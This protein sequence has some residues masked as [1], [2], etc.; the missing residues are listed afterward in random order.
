MSLKMASATPSQEVPAVSGVDGINEEGLLAHEATTVDFLPEPLPPL[1]AEPVLPD[2]E[3][4]E[5][6]PA[7][8]LNNE[9]PLITCSQCLETCKECREIS[10]NCL[11]GMIAI[12]RNNTL[13][14]ENSMQ[15][16]RT[17]KELNRKIQI[18]QDWMMSPVRMIPLQVLQDN[19]LDINQLHAVVSE[20]PSDD[21]PWSVQL[22]ELLDHSIAKHFP[23]FE[24]PDWEQVEGPTLTPVETPKE[25]PQTPPP[26]TPQSIAVTEDFTG[27]PQSKHPDPQVELFVS[28]S[29][30]AVPDLPSLTSLGLEE[31]IGNEPVD[32]NDAFD[33]FN[34]L[35]QDEVLADQ[36]LEVPDSPPK[37]EE[38][39]GTPNTWQTVPA[40][41]IENS[42]LPPPLE[43]KQTTRTPKAK[44]EKRSL[45]TP[46]PQEPD[47]QKHRRS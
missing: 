4:T 12:M 21:N 3:Q 24:F 40:A 27:D 28:P 41:E 25:T 29:P 47:V 15:L 2:L 7:P 31:T 5:R 18:L 32:E 46:Q 20:T 1:D 30:E 23:R 43:P 17:Q 33:E 44:R 26:N 22:L 42:S 34:D 8:Q 19:S 45:V 6:S 11:R 10:K 13:I 37:T 35:L 36:V 39:K 14:M 9:P 16:H 38:E